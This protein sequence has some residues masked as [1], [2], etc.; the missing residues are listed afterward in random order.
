MDQGKTFVFSIA[1]VT[2]NE[3]DGWRLPLV[4]V[5]MHPLMKL[6][7]PAALLCL[8]SLSL[9]A[10]E[11]FEA[12][13]G[14]EAELPGGKEADGIRGDFV[15]RSDKIEAVVSHN[16]P[17][18]RANMSTF[19]GPDGVTPGCLFD[20]TLRGTNNDQLI[21]YGPVG[22]GE[23]SYVKTA[24]VKEEGAAA[25][26]SVT[27]AAKGNGIFKRNEYRVR[28]G[29]Q[30]IFITSI[31]R[32]ETD[33]PQKVNTKADFTR[34]NETGEG[35]GIF[36]TSAVDPA[37]KAGYAQVVLKLEGTEKSGGE[38]EIA[39]GKEVVIHRFLAVGRSAAEA[40]GIANEVRGSEL[41]TLNGKVMSGGKPVTTGRVE[42][43][44]GKSKVTAFPDE[45]GEFRVKLAPGTFDITATDIGRPEVKQSITL[46]KDQTLNVTIEMEAASR[47]D[48]T[49]TDDQGRS[50]PCKA[51]FEGLEG[52]PNPDLGPVMRARG[53]KDQ[54]HSEKGQFSVQLPT[55]KYRIRV[56]RGGEYS[57]LEKIVSLD[58][59]KAFAFKGTL[60]RVLST[61]GW[62]T[63]DFHNHSTQSGDNICGTD[64]RLI[65]YAAEGLEWCPTTEHNRF[66]DWRPHM[67]RLGLLEY[68]N[69]I[70]G[71]E[72]TGS[73]QHFNAFPFTPD[74]YLQDGGAPVWN[75][76]PRITAI[77]LRRHQG[78]NPDRWI[79]FNHPDLINMFRDRD[80]DGIA[81]GGFVGVGTMIDGIETQNGNETAILEGAPYRISRSKNSLAAKATS[82]REFIWLQLLNQGHRLVA[83]GVADAHAVYG[84]GVAGWHIYLKSPTDT[85]KELNWSDLSPHAK[86]GHIIVT[87]GPFLS[88]TT[89]DGKGPGDDARGTGGTTLNVQVQGT[90]WVAIDRVQ[91]LVNGRPDAK[92]NFTRSTHPKMFKDG[93]VQFEERIAVPLESDA[94]LIVVAMGENSTLAGGYGTSDQ[95]KMHPCAYN[96]PIYVDVDGHGFQ[97]NGDTLGYD[98]PVSGVTADRAK[99]LLQRGGKISEAPAIPKPD[100]TPTKK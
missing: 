35:D 5:G 26:E 32:N 78:E 55:G 8:S 73:R 85:P 93:V 44:L 64:D 33:K 48:F 94:H 84:N 95:S 3:R 67:E 88:V 99:E 92:L 27:T 38:I 98:L 40:A 39:P 28:D 89:L 22:H 53:C 17:L 19:Y 91:V 79:Q 56:V 9:P 11:V 59:G 66:Y 13:L 71:I 2:K 81:D 30:G 15:L 18:R 20:L 69:T 50:T 68:F 46:A 76:D 31:L 60:K 34:F 1:Q 21:C 10:A 52:T 29:I 51:M 37:D 42:V 6:I 47:V 90:D 49:I 61:P 86:A 14:R 62:V 25:V 23:V 83:V 7:L 63:S 45:K 75:D 57:S 41:G 16:A 12:A 87:N 77:T 24:A 54:Y 36:W 100:G 74:R 80:S 96:N 65:N 70:P 58:Q 4:C 97:A 72:L 82:V 43:P